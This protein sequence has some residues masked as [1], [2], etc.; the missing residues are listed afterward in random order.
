MDR[1]SADTMLGERVVSQ[2]SLEAKEGRHKPQQNTLFYY[3]KAFLLKSSMAVALLIAT[4]CSFCI[5]SSRRTQVVLM[6]V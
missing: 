1:F 3:N 4:L 2:G 5:G 6:A